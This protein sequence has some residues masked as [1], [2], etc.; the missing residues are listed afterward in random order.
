[1]GIWVE[2]HLPVGIWVVGRRACSYQTMSVLT[3]R[4]AA[5]RKGEP[6][7]I[8]RCLL[9]GGFCENMLITRCHMRAKA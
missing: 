1:M 8:G 9:L 2:H 3:V 7:P 5:T 6:V 4:R